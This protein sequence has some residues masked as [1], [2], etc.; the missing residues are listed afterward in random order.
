MNDIK[1]ITSQLTLEEKASL[2]SGADFWHLKGIERLGIPS[3]MVTDG[4]H[5]LRKQAGSSNEL[6]ISDSVPAT[7]FPTAS[8]LAAAWNRD[9]IFEVGQALGEECRQEKVGVIL[10][11]GVNIKRSP[12]CGRN[13]EYFSEDPYLT[14]EIAKSHIN[15]VQSQGV[16]T[17]LKHYALNN[18]EYRRMTSDSVVDERTMREI[19][20]TGFEIAVKESQPWT[21]MCSYNRVNGTYACENKYL[22]NDILKEEWGHQGLVVT[23]WGAMNER[24][25]A[26]N[27]GVE[28]E[29]PGAKNGN[30]E[31]ILAAVKAGTLD[32]AVLDRAVER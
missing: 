8:A 12:L 17:S 19:Y 27:A 16:G 13:F 11:P 24:V 30:D 22:M 32:V 23:D 21:V 28:L 15:G 29:M 3:I 31:K 25:D 6:G 18:Q 9:L 7:C 4:P 20:L 5:G 14:G 1:T 2:C 10:G 26:L